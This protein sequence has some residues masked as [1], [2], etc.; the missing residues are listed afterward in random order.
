[1]INTTDTQQCLALA[2]H[3]YAGEHQGAAVHAYLGYKG[4]P[5]VLL[6]LEQQCPSRV[7]NHSWRVDESISKQASQLLIGQGGQLKV[8]QGGWNRSGADAK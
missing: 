3:G 1:M 7:V 6:W 2:P 8:S 4:L 5:Q